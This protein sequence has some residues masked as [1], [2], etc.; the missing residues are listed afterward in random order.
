[1]AMGCATERRDNPLAEHD[2]EKG[3]QNGGISGQTPV[4]ILDG[5]IAF[6]GRT[7]HAKVRFPRWQR[8]LLDSSAISVI[9]ELPLP[10]DYGI[11][12]PRIQQSEIISRGDAETL[13]ISEWKTLIKLCP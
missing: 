10:C 8:Q 1:M 13:R 2:L 3:P 5:R 11:D 7:T 4:G 12:P 9:F 6:T